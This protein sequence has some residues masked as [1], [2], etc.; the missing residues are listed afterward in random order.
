MMQLHHRTQATKNPKGGN[1]FCHTQIISIRRA[2][3]S[4]ERDPSKGQKKGGK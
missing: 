1:R 4:Q 3:T 2:S